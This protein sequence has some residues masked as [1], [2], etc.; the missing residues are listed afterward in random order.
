MFIRLWLGGSLSRF[1]GSTF[2]LFFCLLGSLG[3]DEAGLGRCIS[4]VRGA[5]FGLEFLLGRGL[6]RILGGSG[7]FIPEGLILKSA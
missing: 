7:S 5:A 1:R 6:E 4:E 2:V 3:G